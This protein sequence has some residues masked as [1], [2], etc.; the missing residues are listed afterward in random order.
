M[1]PL[2][3]NPEWGIRPSG[4]DMLSAFP[5]RAMRMGKSGSATLR[6]LVAPG[7]RLA[8]CRVIS[9]T[10]EGYGFGQGALKLTRFFRIKPTLIDGR[11]ELPVGSEVEFPF[12]FRLG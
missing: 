10:P 2:I 9:E 5:E 3:L 7:G 8:N 6:C 1:P 4:A 12:G 11:E